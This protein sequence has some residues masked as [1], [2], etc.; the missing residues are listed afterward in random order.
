MLET[1]RT[2]LASVHPIG[3]Y[4][5]L[6]F[7]LWALAYAVRRWLPS[8]WLIFTL[9]PDSKSA[10]SH[11]IQALPTTIVGAAWAGITTGGDPR[12]FV[13]GGIA[14]LAAPVWHHV[15]KAV[16]GPYRGPL[17]DAAARL[18]KRLRRSSG[19]LLVLVLPGCGTFLDPHS[20]EPFSPCSDEEL[21]ILEAVYRARVAVACP[22]GPDGCEAYPALRSEADARRAEWVACQE[23]TA[24]SARWGVSSTASRRLCT[25][26]SSRW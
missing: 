26:R 21:V 5:L 6:A 8:V 18:W 14:G 13:F 20:P 3:P 25:A 9:W 12:E 1:I 11:V 15:L 2:T 19:L 10:V 24:P 17:N 16:P 23:E 22:D 4:A 7:V